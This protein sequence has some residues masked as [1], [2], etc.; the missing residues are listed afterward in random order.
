MWQEGGGKSSLFCLNRWG[1]GLQPYKVSLESSSLLTDP[2]LL[3]TTSG[4]TFEIGERVFWSL[5]LCFSVMN[6]PGEFFNLESVCKQ[7]ETFCNTIVFKHCSI[8]IILYH[9]IEK[10]VVQ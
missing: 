1:F 4:Y 10:F 2:F 9:N 6:E 8:R 7:S 3:F 5:L